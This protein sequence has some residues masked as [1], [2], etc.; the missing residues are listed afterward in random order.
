MGWLIPVP[1]FDDLCGPN[2]TSQAIQGSWGRWGRGHPTSRSMAMSANNHNGQ[3]T[4]ALTICLLNCQLTMLLSRVED[5]VQCC[6]GCCAMLCNYNQ[7]LCN[8]VQDVLQCSAT[9]I[10]CCAILG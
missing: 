7:L 1:F 10:I 4:R 8:F 9:I 6:A 3:N 2:P 5:D